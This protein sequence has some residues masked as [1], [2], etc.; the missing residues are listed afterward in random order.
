MIKVPMI[1]LENAGDDL[2]KYQT[3]GSSGMDLHACSV[4]TLK[5]MERCLVDCGFSMQLPLDLEAQIRPRSGLALKK[6]VTVLNTPG[7]IDSDYR[8]EIKVLL[9]NLGNE[10]FQIEKGDRIAQMVIAPIVKIEWQESNM[11]DNTERSSGG[12]G[13]TG[14]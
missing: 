7:T 3:K 1:R 10:T 2:P 12:F 13:H 14:V 8:G 11:V 5:P 4:H 9:I 6:G